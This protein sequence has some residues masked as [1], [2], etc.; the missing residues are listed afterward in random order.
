MFG[1]AAILASPSGSAAILAALLDA[2]WKPA[3][4]QK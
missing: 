4:Q 3:L 2:G 1:R